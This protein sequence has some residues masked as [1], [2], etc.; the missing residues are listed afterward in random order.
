MHCKTN[1]NAPP[2]KVEALANVAFQVA[3]ALVAC[4]PVGNVSVT[5]TAPAGLQENS[6]AILKS[7]PD[8]ACTVLGP[9]LT[10][11]KQLVTGCALSE[12]S[13]ENGG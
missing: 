9:V 8:P 13:R 3:G 4:R 11:S 1:Q 5:V 12:S 2:V 7:K 10:A 6:T